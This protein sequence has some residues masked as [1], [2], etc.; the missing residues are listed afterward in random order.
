MEWCEKMGWGCQ[1]MLNRIR[2][3]NT[4]R[5]SRNRHVV[6]Q[7]QEG[8]FTVTRHHVQDGISLQLAAFK[9]LSVLR[10]S[11]CDFV[12]KNEQIEKFHIWINTMSILN[13]HHF[14]LKDDLN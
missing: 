2:E 4:I 6:Q 7:S 12:V 1:V 5:I 10:S 11:C 9:C 13:W 3:E 8:E 14:L